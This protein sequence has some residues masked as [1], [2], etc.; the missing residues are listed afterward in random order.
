MPS[1]ETLQER[2][3]KAVEL[4]A[5][6]EKL[7][8]ADELDLKKIVSAIDRVRDE[9]EHFEKRRKKLREELEE[10]IRRD[11]KG[12]GLHG[13]AWEEWANE[14]RDEFADLV[15][16]C[17]A[18]LDRL[19]EKAAAEKKALDELRRRDDRLDE[20]IAR[21]TRR[22]ERKQTDRAGQLSADFHIAE[23]DCRDG[24]AVPSY[25]QP[26]LVA[27]CREHL[28]PLRD[29]GGSVHINSG[30]RHA[31][32]NRAIG[33]ASQSYH[34]YEIRKRAPAADHVQ[35]GRSA[36]AV[37]QWHDAH[38]NPDGMGYYGGF[39]HIDD[40]GYRSRWWGAS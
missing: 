1:A 19:V 34:V 2:R 6:V 9:R 29:S 27:L 32:Y 28:Q 13:D 3:K 5:R 24:T 10:E 40:R 18:R 38:G 25:M 39:T 11:E 33:G 26:H 7:I 16:G 35:A 20:R 4:E 30:Y 22:L 8:V 36:P 23:F 31:A 14:R 37:Q 17:E 12:K 21:I 15:E